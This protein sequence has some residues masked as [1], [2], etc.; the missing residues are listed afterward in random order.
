MN[1]TDLLYYNI[2]R[3]IKSYQDR[4]GRSGSYMAE[5]SGMSAG[6]YSNLIHL[7]TDVPNRTYLLTKNNI[8][9][10]V[11]EMGTSSETPYLGL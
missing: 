9:G 8:A 5:A 1:Y 10:L 2:V 11:N 3:R 7:K 4:N 6:D